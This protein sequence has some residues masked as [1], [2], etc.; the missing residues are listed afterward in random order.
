M[1]ECKVKYIY[2]YLRLFVPVSQNGLLLA[3]PYLLLWIV[4]NTAGVLADCLLERMRTVSVRRLMMV[5]G[6]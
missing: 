4:I 2:M 3:L 6:A 1:S 5:L